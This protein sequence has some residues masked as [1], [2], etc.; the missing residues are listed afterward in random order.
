VTDRAGRTT[1]FTHDALKRLTQ[2][3]NPEGGITEFGYDGNGNRV[4]L[5]DPN[6]NITAFEFDLDNRPLAKTYADGRGMSAQYDVGGL[7]TS[8]TSARGIVTTYSYDANNN[9]VTTM[10]SDGTPGM[11]NTYDSFNRL[12]AV[13][14]G[15]GTNTYNYDANSWLTNSV[16]PWANDAIAYSLDAL[17]RTTNLAVQGSQTVSYGFDVLNRLASVG[18]GT[19]SYS[20]SFSGSSSMVQILKRPNGS[21]TTYQY[22]DLDR[23]TE[24]ANMQSGGQVINEFSYTYNAQDFRDTETVSNGLAFSV[25]NNQVVTNNYNS[26]NQLLASA[27]P[28]QAFIYDADGN[29]TQGYTPDGYLFTAVYDA[30]S[31]LKSIFY[32]NESGVAFSNQCHYAWNSL[33]AELQEFQ[34]GILSNDSRF[35]RLGYLPAQERNGASTVTREYAWGLNMGGGIGGL[36]NLIQ[37]G[38]FYLYLYDGK[39]NVSALLDGS[40]ATAA[41]YAYDPFGVQIAMSGTL[42]QPYRFSTKPYNSATG[43]YDFGYRFYAPSLSRWL[44]R[45]PIQ[46][47]GGINIYA[48]VENNLVNR[49]DPFGLLSPW[50]QMPSSLGNSAQCPPKKCDVENNPNWKEANFYDEWKFH[51]NMWVYKQ[52][53]A[54]GQWGAECSY[55]GN[56]NLVTGTGGS[57]TANLYPDLSL[58]NIVP[59]LEHLLIDPGGPRLLNWQ[60]L[61]HPPGMTLYDWYWTGD[62]PLP[63]PLAY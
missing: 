41:A 55:T 53:S 32:T 28:N 62:T 40:Q 58:N 24:I 4:S 61:P 31:R 13:Y 18:V 11:T 42:D 60:W 46:E 3:I 54:P 37:A 47:K 48:Y 9:L 63:E 44:S 8:R 35:V 6:G 29:M 38:Q 34:N 20:Y 33:L 14:D 45:D 22:D 51:D 16:G 43:F 59:G 57:G 19:G 52:Q 26:L 7:L 1:Y 23:L 56:G 50:D 30:E 27:Q 17:G 25:T 10:Y 12:V 39:G 21:F 2:I 15:V 36:L 5:T 49:I